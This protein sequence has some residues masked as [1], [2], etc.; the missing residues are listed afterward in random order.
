MSGLLLG[1]VLSV[2]ACW[3]HYYYYCYYYYT[4]S[5]ISFAVLICRVI[6]KEPSLA[7]YLSAGNEGRRT[8]TN[9]WDIR[10]LGFLNTEQEC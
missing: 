8:R 1:M 6:S 2:C 3:F 9:H 7:S 4:F 10:S 5:C